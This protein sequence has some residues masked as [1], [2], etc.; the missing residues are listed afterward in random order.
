MQRGNPCCGQLCNG[1][2]KSL[3]CHRGVFGGFSGP[4]S[5]LV[6][7]PATEALYCTRFLSN[8]VERVCACLLENS[9]R[10]N[11]GMRGIHGIR[12][13]KSGR[14]EPAEPAEPAKPAEPCQAA[15]DSINWDDP[16]EDEIQRGE[17]KLPESIGRGRRPKETCLGG[18]LNIRY[19]LIF[20]YSCPIRI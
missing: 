8:L 2:A 19:V 13:C 15:I 4:W 18:M 16:R 5:N 20:A 7:P 3:G 10:L 9:C 1:K 6:P 14:A 11:C 17:E 12:H